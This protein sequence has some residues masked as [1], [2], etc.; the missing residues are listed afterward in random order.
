LFVAKAGAATG[1]DQALPLVVDAILVSVVAVLAIIVL[2][3]STRKWYGYLV[4]GWPIRT[5]EVVA[6]GSG[7]AAAGS[8]PMAS[9]GFDIPGGRCC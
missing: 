7:A 3:D 5:T 2:V 6:G 8:H 1:S 4:Q 9:G